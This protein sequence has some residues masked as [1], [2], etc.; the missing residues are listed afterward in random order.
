MSA[1]QDLPAHILH[2]ILGSLDLT[3]QRSLFL[4]S[5]QL[6]SKW[7][8]RIPDDPQWRFIAHS[9][10]LLTTAVS[11]DC[12]HNYDSSYITLQPRGQ[13]SWSIRCKQHN[14]SVRFDLRSGNAVS[15]GN[16]CKWLDMTEDQLWHRLSG[17]S[18]VSSASLF[19]SSEPVA[20]HVQL[21]AFAQQLFQM[22]CTTKGVLR[23][24]MADVKDLSDNNKESYKALKIWHAHPRKS[25]LWEIDGE[26][27]ILVPPQ[28]DF[29]NMPTQVTQVQGVFVSQGQ[30]EQSSKALDIGP[31]EHFCLESEVIHDFAYKG[32]VDINA[33]IDDQ[34]KTANDWY[35]QMN[36]MHDLG[37]PDDFD[38]M[39]D[40]EDGDMAQLLGA[41]QG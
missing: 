4:C 3:S 26:A 33:W 19:C 39:D 40:L 13:D 35:D 8:L 18:V 27:C 21:K 25:E 22:L 28:I 29:G 10:S 38:N 7:Q 12:C 5:A 41:M 32:N 6:Y 30:L 20:T 9:V 24:F 14:Q 11:E 36:G 16:N 23:L 1:L 31:V 2:Q 17:S 37:Y 15:S 34:H